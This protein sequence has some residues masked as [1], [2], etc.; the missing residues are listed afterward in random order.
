MKRHLVKSALTLGFLMVTSL[1]YAGPQVNINVN[2]GPPPPVIVHAA[3]TMVYLAEPGVYAAVGVPYDIFFFSGRYYYL[4]GADWFWAGGYGGP[5]T[6]VTYS[7]LP[8]GLRKYKVER[9]R[10]Y[11]ERE[12]VVY[13]KQGPAFKGQH[14]EAE[15][16]EHGRG[17]SNGPGNGSG[18]DNG[19]GPGN[20]NGRGNSGKKGK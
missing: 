13:R 9:L 14:F 18:Q 8:P 1:A 20:S 6:Y 2:I 11:R 19:N 4:R 16:H 12:Y 5:W 15:E 7:T 3:P 10:D 17:N